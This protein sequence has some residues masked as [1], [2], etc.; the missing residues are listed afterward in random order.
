MKALTLIQPWATL[1][2]DGRK[3]IE[4]RSWGSLY[5]GPLAIHAGAKIDKE[6]CEDFGYDPKQIAT[7]AI[8]CIVR[9]KNCVRF[10]HP[11]APPDEYGDF[12]PGRYGFIFEHLL[13][14]PEPI[15]ARGSLGLW[16]WTPPSFEGWSKRT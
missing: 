14:P 2:A 3:T 13:I 9:M 6:A 15:P 12:Y 11:D 16:D 4:T 10:P 1:I 8:V 7:R 5:R